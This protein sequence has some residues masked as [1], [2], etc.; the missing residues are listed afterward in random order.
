[1]PFPVEAHEIATFAAQVCR[2]GVR[3]VILTHYHADTRSV[4][5][6]SSSGAFRR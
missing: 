1:M 5:S 3:Y 2:P 6:C 4:A